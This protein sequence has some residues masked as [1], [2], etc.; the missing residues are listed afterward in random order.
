MQERMLLGSNPSVQ[1]QAYHGL[2]EALHLDVQHALALRRELV[3]PDRQHACKDA[4]VVGFRILPIHSRRTSERTVQVAEEHVGRVPIA[5]HDELVRLDVKVPANIL[6]PARFLI[7]NRHIT[8]CVNLHTLVVKAVIMTRTF[9]LCRS[10]A[11][12]SPVSISLASTKSGSSFDPAELEKMTTRSP[13]TRLH[14]SNAAC[15]VGTI[16]GYHM[17]K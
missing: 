10:T 3:R 9:W 4:K 1:Q 5:D 8:A 6:G 12:C 13:N 7:H 17:R 14:S 15:F 11:T 16:V 2:L